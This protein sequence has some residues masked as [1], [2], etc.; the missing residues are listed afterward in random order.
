[1]SEL[2]LAR[3]KRGKTSRLA[4]YADRSGSVARHADIWFF[5]ATLA[6]GSERHRIST[7][8]AFEKRDRDEVMKALRAIPIERRLRIENE[9][10]MARA[11]QLLG[12]ARDKL[13]GLGLLSHDAE[14]NA[15]EGKTELLTGESAPLNE[16][17]ERSVDNSNRDERPVAGELRLIRP[18]WCIAG[19]PRSRKLSHRS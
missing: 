12:E 9:Q 1:M 5:R 2:I 7:S 19:T 17:V 14:P 10:A 11:R 18:I 13:S 15:V 6:A 8:G 4:G 16:Q 3:Q